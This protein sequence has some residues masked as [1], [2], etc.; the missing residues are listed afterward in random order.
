MRTG[1]AICLSAV[2][3]MSAPTVFAQAKPL[4]VGQ[5]VAEQ[6]QLRVELETGSKRT[7]NLSASKRVDLL[8]R[9]QELLDMLDGKKS[10]SELS[11]E[12]QMFAHSTLDWIQAVVEHDDD[13]RMVCRREK[14]IGSNMITRVCRTLGQMRI[15]Q[16]RARQ[17][18]LKGAQH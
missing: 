16:E 6:S 17:S 13:E 5:V 2:L 9:Q 12:Q 3:M 15:D 11:P 8:A 4:R 10:S 7:A 18:I 14:P 1:L